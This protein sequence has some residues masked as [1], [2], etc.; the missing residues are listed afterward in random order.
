MDGAVLS[1][2][3]S[4]INALDICVTLL[5]GRQGKACVH[6]VE[7][8]TQHQEHKIHC[9]HGSPP[10]RSHSQRAGSLN[11]LGNLCMAGAGK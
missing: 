2:W 7:G 11:G 4:V 9:Y 3:K 10:A 8:H 5:E 6:T 1:I